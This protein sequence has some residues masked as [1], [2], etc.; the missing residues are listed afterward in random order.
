MRE[1]LE[2]RGKWSGGEIEKGHGNRSVKPRDKAGIGRLLAV[3]AG[4]VR[5]GPKRPVGQAQL[6]KNFGVSGDADV[7][8]DSRQVALLDL[9]DAPEGAGNPW[10]SLGE[11]LVVEGLPLR[12]YPIGTTIR[13]G[14]ALLELTGPETFGP[15]VTAKVRLAGIVTEG[16]QLVVESEPLRLV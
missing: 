11:N 14:D 10:G 15:L 1:A 7:G 8:S 16:D 12:D 3:C 13:I 4:R 6:N 5:F 2:E 9:R